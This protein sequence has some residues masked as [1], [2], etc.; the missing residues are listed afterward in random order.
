M[1]DIYP[2]D[3]VLGY[4]RIPRELK[5]K[6]AHRHPFTELD[7][8]ERKLLVKAWY[9]VRGAPGTIFF[10][11]LDGVSAFQLKHWT[12]H[13]LEPVCIIRHFY[14]WLAPAYQSRRVTFKEWIEAEPY[15]ELSDHH[16]LRMAGGSTFVQDDPVTV[17]T[18]S[19]D[20]K[21]VRWLSPRRAFLANDGCRAF[22]LCA[23]WVTT[24]VT[25]CAI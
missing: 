10:R 14:R 24:L 18:A 2:R 7:Q 17:G 8:S 6:Q 21:S 5:E 22:R 23:V 15:G 12:K 19:R 13:D 25:S 11:A 16:P 3:H 9:G 20:H 4:A 1:P